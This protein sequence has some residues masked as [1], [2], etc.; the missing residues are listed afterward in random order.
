MGFGLSNVVLVK[1]DKH[2]RMIPEAL[3]VAIEESKKKV[4]ISSI[5]F[6]LC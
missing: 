5:V 2:G 6:C 3:D 4:Q 1:S